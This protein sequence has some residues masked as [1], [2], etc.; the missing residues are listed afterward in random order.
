VDRVSIEAVQFVELIGI[1]SLSKQ[2]A[3]G[4]SLTNPRWLIKN[5]DWI[6]VTDPLFVGQAYRQL[7][8]ENAY[9]DGLVV[10]GST[11]VEIY[12]RASQG[13]KIANCPHDVLSLHGEGY[14]N[15][16][17]SYREPGDSHWVWIHGDPGDPLVLAS[18]YHHVFAAKEVWRFLVEHVRIDD[19]GTGRGDLNIPDETFDPAV[20]DDQAGGT[21]HYSKALDHISR[22]TINMSGGSWTI[23]N[24]NTT[25]MLEVGIFGTAGELNTSHVCLAHNTGFHGH[26]AEIGV[27]P[28]SDGDARHVAVLNTASKDVF[29]MPSAPPATVER[30]PYFPCPLFVRA[31]QGDITGPM[32][33][34]GFVSNSPAANLLYCHNTP[35]SWNEATDSTCHNVTLGTTFINAEPGFKDPSKLDFQPG[36]N[37][38]LVGAAV[39]IART[40]AASSGKVLDVDRAYCIADDYDGMR[41]SGDV[42]W[43]D[44]QTCTVT[45]VDNLQGRVTCAETLSV[46]QGAE[47]FYTHPS[48]GQK[49]ADIGAV[50]ANG[51]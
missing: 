11:H 8:G 30:S 35:Q 10:H 6:K 25:N 31:A 2:D 3:S 20:K 38:P 49:L 48:T 5:A 33:I 39:A 43:V 40:T 42:L 15:G 29:W 44:G 17:G 32:L 23:A 41:P 34:D 24:R 12:G 22:F 45:A 4:H 16:D 27:G 7:N 37:S 51:W 36:T 19:A 47:I 21:R 14:N 1:K 46:G 26:G 50:P 28:V 9:C 13:A 18:E